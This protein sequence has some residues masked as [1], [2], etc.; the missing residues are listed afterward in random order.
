MNTELNR[1]LQACVVGATGYVGQ[2]FITLLADHPWFE[3]TGVTASPRSRGKTYA[4]AVSGRWKME[5]PIPESVASLEVMSTADIDRFSNQSDLV[6]CAVDMEKEPLISLEEAIAMREVPV[7]SNNSANRWTPDVPVILPE[8]NADHLQLLEAQKKRLNTARG[9]IVVKP[10]CSIQSYVPALTPLMEYGPEY[11]FV[12]TYQAVSGAGKTL[13][14]WPEMQENVIPFISGEE[15]KSELEPLKIWGD[16][17]GDHIELAKKPVI[18]A[19][20][21]RVPVL[22]G[23]TAAVFVKFRRTIDQNEILMHWREFSSVPQALEL[24]SA[25]N[26]FI[27]YIDDHNRPQPRLDAMSRHGMGITVGRLRDDPI[28]DVK[29]TCLSSN[30]VRGAAGGAILTAELLYRQGYIEKR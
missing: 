22:E 12:A 20:C 24:P 18:S 23:H 14:E 8:V 26:P 2:R 19:Q 27:R 6:F 15:E 1:K 13:G 25:P 4:E 11:V 9:F 29:F 17:A 30:T 10:N 7:I 21:Y 28:Y 16:F 5:D 3:I